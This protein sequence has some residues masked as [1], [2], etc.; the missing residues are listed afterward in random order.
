MRLVP[1]DRFWRSPF[2][3]AFRC[4]RRGARLVD[5]SR[6]KMRIGILCGVFALLPFTSL[7]AQSQPLVDYHQHLFSPAVAKLSPGLKTID[8]SDLIALLFAE[9]WCC[10]SPI[11]SAIP[12]SQPS[13]TSM[14]KSKPR[15][16]GPA[17]KLRAFPI[18]C[19]ASAALTH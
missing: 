17:D 14:P 3:A 6:D 1:G 4:I 18:A 12:T 19:G 16:I 5:N 13:K 11:N 8:A 2:R 15:T 9:P 7:H 10:R